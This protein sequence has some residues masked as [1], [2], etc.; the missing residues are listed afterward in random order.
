MA[1]VDRQY[2]SQLSDIMEQNTQ[3]RKQYM[4]KCEE[5]FA[6]A[7]KTD[8]E[9]ADQLETTKDVMKVSVV[10]SYSK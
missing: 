5:L 3:L 2:R 6:L 4:K 7:A 1:D 9:K 10:T 8:Q